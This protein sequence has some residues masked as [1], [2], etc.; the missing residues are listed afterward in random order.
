LVSRRSESLETWARPDNANRVTA[1]EQAVI[2]R[3]EKRDRFMV[4][5]TVAS[6]LF[7]FTGTAVAVAAF[8]LVLSQPHP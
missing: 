4:R 6:V 8:V 3:S 1:S 7:G 2:E 5:L